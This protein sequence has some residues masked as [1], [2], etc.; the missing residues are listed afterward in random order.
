MLLLTHYKY[1]IIKQTI[2]PV[3][4]LSSRNLAEWLKKHTDFHT[5]NERHKRVDRIKLRHKQR[6]KTNGKK[7]RVRLNIKILS[8]VIFSKYVYVD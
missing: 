2:L 5:I 6:R 8:F 7:K 4:Y 1:L 3:A